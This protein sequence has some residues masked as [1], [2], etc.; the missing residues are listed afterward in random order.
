M[1]RGLIVADDRLGELAAVARAILHQRLPRSSLV[2]ALGRQSAPVCGE[3]RKAGRLIYSGWECQSNQWMSLCRLLQAFRGAA[4]NELL[5]C[6]GKGPQTI[7]NAEQ[8]RRARANIHRGLAAV[9][10]FFSQRELRLSPFRVI[11]QNRPLEKTLTELLT[12]NG[13]KAAGPDALRGRQFDTEQ[14]WIDLQSNSPAVRLFRGSC[15]VPLHAITRGFVSGLGQLL[16]GYLVRSVQSDGRMVYLYYPSRGTEDLS[17]NNAIRQWMATRA[18]LQVGR[19]SPGDLQPIVRRNIEYNLQTMYR[20]EGGLGL[21]FDGE[22]VKLGAVALAALALAEAP[23]ADEYRAILQRLCAT[24]SALW[25]ESGQFRTFYRPAHRNDCQNFYPGE[26]LLLWARLL[27]TGSDTSL[28]AR[29]WRS[30]EYY[31]RWH[32]AHRNPAFI[33]W[34]TQ[35]YW[36]VWQLTRD[37]RLAEAILDMNDWLLAVQQWESTP[38]PDCRGRFYDPHRPFG[39]PHAS[40]TGVYLEGLADAWALARELGDAPRLANY[41][42]A[43]LRGLRSI[44]QL[45]FKDDLDM[46]YVTQ[47]DRLRGGVRTT[48]YHNV[49]RIDNVQ[50]GWMA[51]QKVLD[52]FTDADFAALS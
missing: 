1:T 8:W 45:T 42:T 11:A 31:Q 36:N 37:R 16:S 28:A 15:L 25:T 19:R 14:F 18:L 48:E 50:H 46:F 27:A 22:K 23:L 20:E 30:F 33:P 13:R 24:V 9:E 44:A 40:S 29:F 17:R 49:V 21:I 34:H 52:V 47:R 43:I 26:A 35:A 41:R 4:G 5:L 10:L 2:D 32:K 51:I 12:R 38:H 39:P 6:F 3:L 7:N